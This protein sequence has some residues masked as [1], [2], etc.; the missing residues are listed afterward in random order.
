MAETPIGGRKTITVPWALASGL[1]GYLPV[2]VACHVREVPES[3]LGQ[4]CV[5]RRCVS[6]SKTKKN[7]IVYELTQL[8]RLYGSNGIEPEVWIDVLLYLES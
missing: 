8:Q 4:R 5:R 1:G 6:R 3:G 2:L 7:I